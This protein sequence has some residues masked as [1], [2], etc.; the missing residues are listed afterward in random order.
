MTRDF[1]NAVDYMFGG[2]GKTKSRIALRSSSIK[3]TNWPAAKQQSRSLFP[4]AQGWLPLTSPSLGRSWPMTSWS[5]TA[6]GIGKR[7]CSLSSSDTTQ[8]YNFLVALAFRRCSICCTRGPTMFKEAA[9]PIMCTGAMG[10]GRQHRAGSQLEKIVAVIR[11]R[12]ISLTLFHQHV[13]LQ[14]KAI[15]DKTRRN[16]FGKYGQRDIPSKAGRP[17]PSRKYPRT[18]WVRLPSPCRPTAAP[19]P[20]GKLQS[21]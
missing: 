9:C 3:S 2:P 7:W 17:A 6:S 19:W 8:T 16:H 13:V 10:R 5:L 20:V 21:K 18:G 1:M 4:A 12:E 15:Y 11:S 14:C